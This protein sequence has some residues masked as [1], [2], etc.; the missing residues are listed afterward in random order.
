[1]PWLRAPVKLFGFTGFLLVL[2]RLLFPPAD[3]A[4]ASHL[5]S[6]VRFFDFQ[7]DLTGYGFFE[8][9]GAVFLFSAVTYYLIFRLTNR[10]PNN[11][12]IQ[13]HFWPSLLFAIFSIFLAYRVN[14]TS[15]VALKDP[16][17]VT[18]LNR[19]L[20]AFTWAFAVFLIIQLTFALAA[21]RWIWAS[22]D[23]RAQ[24]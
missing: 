18:P 14:S 7:L 21:A 4:G 6:Y 12:L 11:A 5:H 22:R 15:A 2:V 13:L 20:T 1:M 24:A 19:Y 23:L 8:F 3:F 10:L 16:S 17:I 9:A